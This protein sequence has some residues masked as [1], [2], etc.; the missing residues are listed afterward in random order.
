MSAQ[1]AAQPLVNDGHDLPSCALLMSD[2]PWSDWYSVPELAP[3]IHLSVATIKRRLAQWSHDG[4]PIALADGSSLPIQAEKIAR[5]QGDEWRVRVRGALPPVSAAPER[6]DSKPAPPVS[7]P[8]SA[9][10]AALMAVREILSEERSERRKL[11]TENA[12]LSERAGRAEL[13]A[14]QLAAERERITTLAAERNEL[15]RQLTL[16]EERGRRP[17]WRRW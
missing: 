15:R 16:A 6:P 8:M 2:Q 3:R 14:E 1:S 12:A 13:L 11:A 7:A 5:P 9:D 17:W 10:H 4:K